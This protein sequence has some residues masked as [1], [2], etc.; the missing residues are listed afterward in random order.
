LAGRPHLGD[1]VLARTRKGIGHFAFVA[2]IRKDCLFL[3]TY[4]VLRQESLPM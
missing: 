1:G 3:P 4:F 2:F